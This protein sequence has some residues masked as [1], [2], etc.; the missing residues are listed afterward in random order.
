MNKELYQKGLTIRRNVLGAQYVDKSIASAD[1]F[2]RPL[3]EFV[4]EYCWGATWGREKL[5]P[6]IRSIINLAMLSALN[7]GH[8][9]KLHVNGALNNGVEKEEIVEILLQVGIYCGVP[10]AVESFRLAQEAF[11]ERGVS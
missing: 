11:T 3:Q 6:K 5:S 7:R 9:F 8:E 10:A 1:D 2:T 4:T